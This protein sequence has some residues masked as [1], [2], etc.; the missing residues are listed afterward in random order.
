MTLNG[1]RLAL[2]GCTGW[3]WW[4]AAM[5]DIELEFHDVDDDRWNDLVELFEARGG[6]HYCW[7]MA[8][9][10]KLAG[11]KGT[12]LVLKAS[13]KARVDEGTPIG[14]LGYLEGKPVAWCSI[15]PRSS[16][17]P[18]G[19]PDE[20]DD[21]ESVWSIVCFFVPRKLRGQGVTVQLIEAAIARAKDCG[22]K[23]IESYPVDPTSPTYKFM[24]VT[25]VF[26]KAGFARIGPAGKRRHIMRLKLS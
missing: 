13:L 23:I 16:Y 12:K 17:R 11:K 25:T 24:G 6:P 10:R 19:G 8:W 22:A 26:Q 1:S 21:E 20:P 15:A 7:C 3:P 2:V 9:R 18:L 4:F 5:S 14:I